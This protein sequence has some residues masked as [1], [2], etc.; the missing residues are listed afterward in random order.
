NQAAKSAEPAPRGRSRVGFLGTIFDNRVVDKNALGA[1]VGNAL[2]RPIPCTTAAKAA[3]VKSLGSDREATSNASSSLFSTHSRAGLVPDRGGMTRGFGPT[4]A[5]F[6]EGF[7]P[8]SER[9][10]A[11]WIRHASRTNPGSNT[12]GSGERGSKAWVTYPEDRD[13]RPNGRVIPG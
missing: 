4:K 13:S 11:A 9:T 12:G 1:R 6:F 2:R 7:D 3:D 8:G 10:L 5:T